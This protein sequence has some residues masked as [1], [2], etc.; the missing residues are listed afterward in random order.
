M[1]IER[2]VELL[3][4]CPKRPVLR[5]IIV[6]GRIGFADLRESIDQRAAEA[7]FFNATGQFLGGSL[8]VLQRQRREPFQT[9]GILRD[10]LG[11]IVVRPPR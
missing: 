5:Q 2:Y 7:Q 1:K 4:C 10:V 6:D 3:D 9:F 11:Q 8:R